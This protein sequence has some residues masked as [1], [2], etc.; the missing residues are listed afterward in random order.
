MPWDV[1][2]YVVPSIY[3]DNKVQL[4]TKPHRQRIAVTSWALILETRRSC[5]LFAALCSLSMALSSEWCGKPISILHSVPMT[6]ECTTK[7]S[8][9]A[10]LEVLNCYCVSARLTG[11]EQM[12]LCKCGCQRKTR[13]SSVTT[14]WTEYPDAPFKPMTVSELG[15][16]RVL[17]GN[18]LSQRNNG[19]QKKLLCLGNLRIKGYKASWHFIATEYR[20]SVLMLTALNTALRVRSTPTV[21]WA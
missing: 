13:L 5:F 20:P 14:W 12:R 18:F 8:R 21:G 11:S 6:P 4:P 9:V 16:R 17:P 15:G 3:L 1:N 7:P 19:I 2:A 10:R